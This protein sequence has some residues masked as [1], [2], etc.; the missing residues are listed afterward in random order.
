MRA[1]VPIAEI[2]Q[3]AL[4]GELKEALFPRNRKL[5]T[6]KYFGSYFIAR[7]MLIHPAIGLYSGSSVSKL[8]TKHLP[9]NIS[10]IQDMPI[11]F[12]A[13]SVDMTTTKP[14]WLQDGDIAMAIRASNSAPGF[15]RPVRKDDLVLIDGGIRS[16]LPVEI[17]RA[18]QAPAVVAV[19]LHSYLERIDPKK[20]DTMLEFGDRLASI[21][22]SE[23]ESKNIADANVLIEPKI[24]W[25]EMT[26]FDRKDLEA[27][28]KAG[29]DAAI[30]ALPSIREQ[31]KKHAFRE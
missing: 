26:S 31:M 8:V 12:A 24:A 20:F 4:S 5:Q 25:M 7:S 19:R 16:N 22:L 11:A 27:S 21:M 28:I 30:A 17:S 23:I 9:R 2:E 6:V 14:V 1:G 15:F 3:M 18:S 10:K 13:A 29:E